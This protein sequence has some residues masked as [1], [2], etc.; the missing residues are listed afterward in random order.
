MN[1]LKPG[2]R[3]KLFGGYDM[4]PRWLKDRDC[5]YATVLKFFDNKIEKRKGD[6]RLSAVIE[7]DD[8]VTFEG[9][10]GKY[11]V[12]LGRWEGQLWERKGVVHVHL[13]DREVSDSSEITKDNSRWMESH[14]SYECID[15]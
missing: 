15:G 6:E 14:A 11:G 8:L 7:F 5:Y 10:Q 12:I 4:D 3:I 2:D 13:I 9:L 1:K